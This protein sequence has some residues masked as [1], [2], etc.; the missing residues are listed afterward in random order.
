MRIDPHRL[1]ALVALDRE[2]TVT[3]AAES[4]HYGQST[5]THHLHRLQVETGVVL[6]QRVGRNLRLTAE[7]RRLARQGQEILGL[8]KRAETDLEA[9][10]ALRV[11]RVRMAVFPS[12]VATL[13]PAALDALR[14]RAP[15]I[16]LDLVEAEPPQAMDMLSRGDVDLALAFAY[17]DSEIPE[18][19]TRTT[20]FED[21]LLLVTSRSAD[22]DGVAAFSEARWVTGCEQ[23]RSELLR[24]CGANGFEPAVAM[25]T[26]DYVAA[27]ALV[28][29]GLGVTILPQLALSA[30]EHPDVRTHAIPGH[31]RSIVALGLGEPPLPAVHAL[32]MD[33]LKDVTR[34]Q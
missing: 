30:Y 26:D 12:A 24:I 32:V 20:L 6:F 15:G 13:L 25:A 1:E 9:A 18:K 17:E 21:P 16:V 28:A 4:L 7:G 2:G 10:S 3:K 23:C 33:V 31:R 22:A 14:R 27:Q 29:S 5:I 19:F 11:G 34:D 8:L